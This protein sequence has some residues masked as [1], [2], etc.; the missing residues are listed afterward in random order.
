M[1]N[2]LAEPLGVNQS[3]LSLSCWPLRLAK[4]SPEILA[5]RLAISRLVSAANHD[6]HTSPTLLA[7][8]IAP[9]YEERLQLFELDAHGQ[10]CSLERV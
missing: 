7:K 2:R 1:R 9:P 8:I 10:F 4:E 5:R 6:V 3:I